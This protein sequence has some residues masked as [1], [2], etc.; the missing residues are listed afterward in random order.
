MLSTG[1]GDSDLR[2]AANGYIAEDG[3]VTSWPELADGSYLVVNWDGTAVTETQIK[4]ANGR[5]DKARGSVFCVADN[6]CSHPDLQGA[7]PVVQR[8][9][10]HRCRSNP[11]ANGRSGQLRL[12]VDWD[13][14]TSNWVIEGEI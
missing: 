11:L 6:G 2:P 3:T 10:Q 12:V 13:D 8:G 5:S 1:H 4:I 9:R 14:D 7:K